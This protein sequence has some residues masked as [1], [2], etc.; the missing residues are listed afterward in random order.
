M[1]NRQE[2]IHAKGFSITP[3]ID[4]IEDFKIRVGLQAMGDANLNLNYFKKLDNTRGDKMNVLKAL[5][6][7]D[8]KTLREIS[9]LFYETSGIYQ[10]LCKYLAY[11]Y[12]YDWYVIPFLGLE[13]D[14]VKNN[15][16]ILTEFTSLLNYLDNSYLKKQ[17]GDIALKVVRE[18]VYYGIAITG[19]DYISFQELPTNYCRSRFSC[20]GFPAV[21]FNMKYF[22]DTFS[23]VAYR[24]R[25]INSFPKDIIKGY[26]LYKQG[27]LK[28]DFPGDTNGWYLL[29]SDTAFKL[30]CAGS[31][32][33]ILANVIPSII[34]LGEAQELDRKKTM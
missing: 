24:L 25:I 11:L 2:E 8:Y 6:S 9:N 14:K 34:D 3:K 29:N 12:K 5:K 18:G 1:R 10:R 15:N 4:S 21:E 17:M 16:K 19:N 22:D 31:D 7:H 32:F 28:P 13:P 33:P 20:N 30:N 27:K 23:D 26:T